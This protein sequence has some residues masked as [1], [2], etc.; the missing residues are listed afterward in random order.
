[1]DYLRISVSEFNALFADIIHHQLQLNRLCI[2]GEVTQ[3][4]THNQHVYLTLSENQCHIPCV[5]YNAHHKSI[6]V[7][8]TGNYCDIIGAYRYLKYK[9]QLIF[10]GES[11]TIHG[12]GDHLL[13]RSQQLQTYAD[14][15]K[16]AIKVRDDIPDIIEKIVLI[17]APDSAAY[18][19]IKSILS[20]TMHTFE[21]V[22][23]PSTV[24][25]ALAPS[26][27]CEAIAAARLYDPDLICVSRG[28]GSDHDFDCFFS[29]DVASAILDTPTPII[30]GIGH[31]INT[32]LACLCANAHFETP[33]AM[34][35]WLASHSTQR[36]SDYV[37]QLQ[38]IR[39]S[40]ANTR[41]QLV[42]QIAAL[43]QR[44]K[45]HIT[46]QWHT[47]SHQVGRLTEQLHQKNPLNRIGNGYAYVT[48][49]KKPLCS[50][51]HLRENDTITLR[52][53]DG[54]CKGVVVHVN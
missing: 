37:Q 31:E 13:R 21:T 24:Q 43:N 15:G 23:V 42:A 45:T 20:K 25:G 11:V 27:L 12:R 36:L 16:F 22:L 54:T 49:Q 53:P 38:R 46:N 8:A 5:I 6:P 32:T 17:T 52:L 33:T 3:V 7:I 34:I 50:V 35:Q 26:A 19:D 1:M 10:S 29:D 40:I 30:C 4:S 14:A 51:Q 47:Y 48:H 41:H 18:H 39:L 44:G 28:G 2:H 9:G